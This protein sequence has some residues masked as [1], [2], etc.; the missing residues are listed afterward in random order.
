MNASNSVE[1]I[2][3]FEH[4]AIQTLKKIALGVTEESNRNIKQIELHLGTAREVVTEEQRDAMQSL[5]DAIR[6][7]RAVSNTF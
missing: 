3:P 7:V 1:K 5:A 2:G 6:K 4:K